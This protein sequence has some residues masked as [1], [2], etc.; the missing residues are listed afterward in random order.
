[1]GVNNL[2][3]FVDMELVLERF[4]SFRLEETEGLQTQAK[5]LTADLAIDICRGFVAALESANDPKSESVLTERQR[6]IAIK[7]SMFLAACAKIGL[8]ALI[9]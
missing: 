6:E 7:A 2:K 9:D 8:D 4:V 1:M 5:G 3:G